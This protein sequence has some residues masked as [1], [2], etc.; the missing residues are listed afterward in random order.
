M[1]AGVR[2]TRFQRP[3]VRHQGGVRVRGRDVGKV[4]RVSGAA[5]AGQ[6][7]ADQG[8]GEGFFELVEEASGQD[9]IE[10]A[11]VGGQ[12]GGGAQDVAGAAAVWARVA[13][14]RCVRA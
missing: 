11:V 13:G 9:Q 6:G 1:S 14:G 4:E 3:D 5:Q 10:G 12:V 8:S 2:S 7:G